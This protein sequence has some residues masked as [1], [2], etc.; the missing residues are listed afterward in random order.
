MVVVDQQAQD[1]TNKQYSF[2][3]CALPWTSRTHSGHNYR[4]DNLCYLSSKLYPADFEEREREILKCQLQHYEHGILAHPK[5]KNLTTISEICQQ[6]AATGKNDDYHLIDTYI[7]FFA[8]IRVGLIIAES[9]N[10]FLM[11][12][13]IHPVLTLPVSTATIECAFSE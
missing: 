5:F 1:S 13:L 9:S 8:A 11:R 6:L 4:C 10:Y 2:L 3:L 7:L 12:I